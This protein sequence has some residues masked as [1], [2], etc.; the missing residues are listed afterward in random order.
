[1]QGAQYLGSHQHLPEEALLRAK[2]MHPLPAPD[3]LVLGENIEQRMPELRAAIV[4]HLQ[5]ASPPEGVPL[6]CARYMLSLYE[7]IAELF[8]LLLWVNAS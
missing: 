5:Y 3:E 8:C 7:Q 4:H 1:M 6:Q 2:E